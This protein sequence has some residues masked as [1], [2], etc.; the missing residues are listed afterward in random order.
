M[1][2]ATRFFEP[3][4]TIADRSN[5]VERGFTLI[6]V[7]IAI[8]IFASVGV[9]LFTTAGGFARAKKQ[10]DNRRGI[11]LLSEQVLSR[12]L[13]EGGRAYG[14]AEHRLISQQGGS[15][16]AAAVPP[17]F[18]GVA[19][20]EGEDDRDVVTFI[21]ER[22]GQFL[23]D[24]QSTPLAAAQKKRMVFPITKS[25]RSFRCRFFNQN[26]QQWSA[27]W[28]DTPDTASRLPDVIEFQITLVAVGGLEHSYTTA[29]RLRE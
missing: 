12:L 14:G 4:P 2:R 21:I 9:V 1:T 15:S 29:V 22:G 5:R 18:R 19:G 17:L 27:S 8:A 26:R 23:P 11:E 6:E 10:L 28:G 24:Q 13:S 3:L 20:K 7:V 16:P 25:I